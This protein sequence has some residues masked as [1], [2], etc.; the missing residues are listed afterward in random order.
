MKVKHILIA[1]W[2]V[3]GLLCAATILP[4]FIYEGL[5]RRCYYDDGVRTKTYRLRTPSDF[6]CR[7]HLQAKRD[8]NQ[9][10]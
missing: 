7:K 6:L 9:T 2:V 4:F 3:A 8:E 10:P 1:V 5:C